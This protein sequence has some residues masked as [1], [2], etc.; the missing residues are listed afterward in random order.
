[1]PLISVI[2][3]LYNKENFI[4]NTLKSVLSQTFSDF[5]ILVINDGSTDKSE[6]KVLGFKE[7]KIRYFSKTNEGVS[8]TRNF[9]IENAQG[10]YI[11]FIDADDIWENDFLENMNNLILSFP[12]EKVFSG[13]IKIQIENRVFNAEYSITKESPQIVDYF[14]GSHLNGAICTSASVFEKSVFETVGNFDINLKRDEDTDLWIRVGLKFNVV[15][16]WTIG[17]TYTYDPNSLTNISKKIGDK[18]DFSKYSEI[19][20]TNPK[21]EKFLDMNRFAFALLSKIAGEKDG[22][23]KFRRQINL[24][25]L[26]QKQRFLLGLPSWM[27][28]NLYSLKLLLQRNNIRISTFK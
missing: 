28:R 24:K 14:D 2:I 8:A 7:A 26:N 4:E 3:P 22:F 19:A 12:N 6:E 1:M 17:A 13:A 9:G 5:E 10:E 15:F 20:K 25:N 21:L 18:T 23:E 16:S 27:L 11:A